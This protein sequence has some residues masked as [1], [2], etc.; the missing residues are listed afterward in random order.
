M[1]VISITE[2]Q[3]QPRNYPTRGVCSISKPL[4]N[5]HTEVLVGMM[6][7][8]MMV[9]TMTVSSLDWAV[10]SKATDA[11]FFFFFFTSALP[12][13]LHSI[14]EYILCFLSTLQTPLILPQ[15]GC[16]ALDLWLLP[17][18]FFCSWPA[19]FPS[20]SRL[21]HLSPWHYLHACLRLQLVGFWQNW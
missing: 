9:M 5:L 16:A 18:S 8:M 20:I 10:Q 1:D 14:F 15:G 21:F 4:W 11:F 2:V 6:I 12:F 7:M 17:P 19:I 3:P 13:P